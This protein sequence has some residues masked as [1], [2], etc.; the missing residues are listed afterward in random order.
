VLKKKPVVH[1]VLSRKRSRVQPNKK[2]KRWEENKE[3]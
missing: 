1:L 3:R 2:A